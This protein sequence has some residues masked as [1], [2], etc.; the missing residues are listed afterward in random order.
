MPRWSPLSCCETNPSRP[1]K[2]SSPAALVTN[3]DPAVPGLIWPSSTITSWGLLGWPTSTGA[4]RDSFR[5]MITAASAIPAP[6][7][8]DILTSRRNE[9][10]SELRRL[11]H[12]PKPV[13]VAGVDPL[14]NSRRFLPSHGL[15]GPVAR[16]VQV[17]H[18]NVAARGED[19]PLLPARRLEERQG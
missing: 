4:F 11:W 7:P 13:G 10:I 8:A 16:R 3:G 9:E 18:I 1:T 2:T 5:S 14:G 15:D 12:G 6:T 19:P 17:L